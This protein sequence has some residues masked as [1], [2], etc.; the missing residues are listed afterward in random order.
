MIARIVALFS[1]VAIL[2]ACNASGHIQATGPSAELKP[3]YDA[4]KLVFKTTATNSI[5][6]VP[7]MRGAI[8]GVLLS[9]GRFKRIVAETDPADLVLNLDITDYRRV[10]VAERVFIGAMAGPNRL[11]VMVSATDGTTGAVVR[12]FQATGES[13]AHPLSGEAG[14]SDALREVAKQVLVGLN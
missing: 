14:Y 11:T 7:D 12:Q 13:A 4:I 5:D 1:L 6:I 9:T 3:T 10:G 8:V 2:A